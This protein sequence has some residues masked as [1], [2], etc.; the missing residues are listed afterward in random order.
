MGF[1]WS[2]GLV[3][4]AN[5][6]LGA[7]WQR[8]SSLVPGWSESSSTASLLKARIITQGKA[9]WI[10]I[11]SAAMGLKLKNSKKRLI[12]KTFWKI[13]QLMAINLGA[14]SNSFPEQSSLMAINLEA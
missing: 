6:W 12:I 14:P 10:V 5:L 8:L 4:L 2:S 1:Y 11:I 3:I 9:L 7:R 13:S